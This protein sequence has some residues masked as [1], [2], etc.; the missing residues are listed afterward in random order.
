MNDPHEVYPPHKFISSSWSKHI[1]RN[2]DAERQQNEPAI[3]HGGH[4]VT[5]CNQI[6]HILKCRFQQKHHKMEYGYLA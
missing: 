2:K 6:T 4:Y 3:W 5:S 1:G